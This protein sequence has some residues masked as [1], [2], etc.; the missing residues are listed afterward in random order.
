VFDDPHHGFGGL[1]RLQ[2]LEQ[3]PG[4]V[5]AG[6]SVIAGSASTPFLIMSVWI[7]EK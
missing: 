3:R 1:V 7:R 4:D 2:A 6:I 5:L